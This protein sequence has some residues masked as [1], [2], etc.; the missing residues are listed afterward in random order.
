M[1]TN[2]FCNQIINEKL[3]LLAAWFFDLSA[4]HAT[5]FINSC[6]LF[7]LQKRSDST[8]SRVNTVLK[9]RFKLWDSELFWEFFVSDFKFTS[10]CC[11]AI[12]SSSSRFLRMFWFSCLA[13]LKLVRKKSNTPKNSSLWLVAG[14]SQNSLHTRSN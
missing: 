11:F 12:F 13:S 3:N 1:H 9:L 6:F 4:I 8:K 5:S 2:W 7:F 14:S 10:W